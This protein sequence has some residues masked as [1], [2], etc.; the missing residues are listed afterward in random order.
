MTSHSQDPK[1]ESAAGKTS[2][3]DLPPAG[4]HETPELTDDEK[5]PG[6][7]SLPDSEGGEADVGSE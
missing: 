4:P 7:G 5:T 2:G 1:H 6:T 3:E